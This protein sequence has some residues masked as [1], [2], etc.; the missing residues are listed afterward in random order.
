[1]TDAEKAL[2]DYAHFYAAGRSTLLNDV[3]NAVYEE[4]PKT[5]AQREHDAIE[6]MRAHG[7]E[8]DHGV[9]VGRI[10]KKHGLL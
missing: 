1:M 2:I 9:G 5:L 8:C 10:L 3:L 4:R 6:E 7:Y